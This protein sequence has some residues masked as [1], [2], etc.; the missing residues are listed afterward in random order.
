M[1]IGAKPYFCD[2]CGKEKQAANHWFVGCFQQFTLCFLTW[3]DAREKFLLDDDK[4]K[5]FC[6]QACTHKYLDRF[7]N[8]EVNG[9]CN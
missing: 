2:I 6:G 8:G 4:S 1:S 5:H 3:N 9:G 7:L